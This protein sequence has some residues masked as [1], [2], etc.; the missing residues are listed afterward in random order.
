[1]GERKIFGYRSR[2]SNLSF[3]LGQSKFGAFG[4]SEYIAR[5]EINTIWRSP[6]IAL[7]IYDSPHDNICNTVA[8]TYGT[9]YGTGML[10]MLQRDTYYNT[11]TSNGSLLNGSYTRKASLC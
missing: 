10:E 5:E 2:Q 3:Q 8:A 4:K 9:N 1:M 6:Y 11:T 7:Y